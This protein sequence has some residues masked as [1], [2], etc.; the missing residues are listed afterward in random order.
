[1]KCFGKDYLNTPAENIIEYL[2]SINEF[3]KTDSM[4]HYDKKL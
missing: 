2:K 3:V 4:V 1:M